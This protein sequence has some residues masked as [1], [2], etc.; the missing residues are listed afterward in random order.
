M[1]LHPLTAHYLGRQ[2]YEPVWR[3]MQALTDA[4]DATTA[5]EIW[6]LDHDPVFTLGQAGKP[7]HV[8]APGDI[9]VLKVDRGGQVT[10]HGPGQLIAYPLLDLR[11]LGLGV[12]E[13]VIRL[14]QVGID[15]LA[16]FDIAA[17]RRDGAPGLY[18]AGRKIMAIGIRVRRGCTFHGIALNADMDLEPFSRINPCGY[19]GLEVTRIADFASC[20]VLPELAQRYL[21]VF[22]RVFGFAY[23][24]PIASELPQL[25]TCPDQGRGV[26]F[27][28]N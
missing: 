23:A 26:R 11:R 28:P 7:E 15:L 1:P 19:R 25:S 24:P 12:R 16:E 20:P 17:E 22:T 18:V 6:L 3:A 21:R 27:A 14:E 10:Y 9:P 2:P 4:R 8:L 13:L 5:D